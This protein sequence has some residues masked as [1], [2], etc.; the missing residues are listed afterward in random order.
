MGGGFFKELRVG[1]DELFVALRS[2]F[3]TPQEREDRARIGEIEIRRVERE[4]GK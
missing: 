1:S 2:F 3:E 4:L